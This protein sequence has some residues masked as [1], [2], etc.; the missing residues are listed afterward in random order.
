LLLKNELKQVGSSVE[1]EVNNLLDVLTISLHAK[2]I[3]ET[4]DDLCLTKSS[5]SREHWR[6]V[7]LHQLT[8]DV[9]CRDGI[10]GGHSVALNTLRSI[11]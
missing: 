11:N 8:H 6:V 3:E 10:W 7:D 1:V 2:L 9:L 5:K 4:L